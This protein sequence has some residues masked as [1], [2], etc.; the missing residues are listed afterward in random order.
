MITQN[1][2]KTS[3][4]Q[5][6]KKYSRPISKTQAAAQGCVATGCLVIVIA[7]AIV[8]FWLLTDNLDSLPTPLRWVIVGFGILFA[9]GLISRYLIGLFSGRKEDELIF[10]SQ[11]IEFNDVRKE[12]RDISSGKVVNYPQQTQL[13]LYAGAAPSVPALVVSHLETFDD[14]EEILQGIRER[15]QG[16]LI[17][18]SKEKEAAA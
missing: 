7:V 9:V 5:E 11:G 3:D 16:R 2:D 6:G 10:D 13:I 14:N 1:P 8:N 18:E 12:W 4:Q 15:L 17:E